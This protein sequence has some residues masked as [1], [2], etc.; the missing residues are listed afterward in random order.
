MKQIYVVFKRIENKD[1]FDDIKKM[2][3]LLDDLS[4]NFDLREE[5]KKAIADPENNFYQML[6]ESKEVSIY[7]TYWKSIDLLTIE[8]LTEKIDPFKIYE[9]LKNKFCP[10][11]WSI[12][13]QQS[14]MQDLNV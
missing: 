13:E 1:V 14:Q 9:Y 3:V 10:K 4:V 6:L 8:I 11:Y 7:I 2:Y 5:N 12:S